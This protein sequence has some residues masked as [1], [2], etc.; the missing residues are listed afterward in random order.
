MINNSDAVKMHWSE[1]RAAYLRIATIS[2]ESKEIS[3]Q[4]RV[5]GARSDYDTYLALGRRFNELQIEWSK[6]FL[7]FKDA[8]SKLT[9]HMREM[10][11]PADDCRY[12]WRTLVYDVEDGQS[13][14]SQPAQLSLS[15]YRLMRHSIAVEPAPWFRISGNCIREGPHDGIVAIFENSAWHADGERFTSYDVEGLAA[16][17]LDDESHVEVFGPFDS[18]RM[19]SAVLWTNAQP[20]AKFSSE[21]EL[22]QHVKSNTYWPE[23]VIKPG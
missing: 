19:A 21:T 9:A 20:L 3:E 22:W 18:V 8:Q 17:Q 13:S 4:M 1:A 11:Y 10:M 14:G 16:V 6:A 2:R 23:M 5:V 15:L 7:M 12:L